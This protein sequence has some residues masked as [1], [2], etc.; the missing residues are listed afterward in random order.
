MVGSAD[1]DPI[2]RAHILT[3]VFG[4]RVLTAAVIIIRYTLESLRMLIRMVF[5]AKPAA[6]TSPLAASTFYLNPLLQRTFSF[7]IFVDKQ[8]RTHQFLVCSGPLVEMIVSKNAPAKRQPPPNQ[9]H[10]QFDKTNDSKRFVHL[11]S[12]LLILPGGGGNAPAIITATVVPSAS[13]N[14]STTG[15]SHLETNQ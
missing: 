13:I 11:T 2:E 8:I 15:R 14:T 5:T 6:S 3:A 1:R 12:L 9:Q 7:S 4:S 10:G